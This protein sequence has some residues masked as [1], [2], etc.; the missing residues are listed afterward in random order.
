MEGVGLRESTQGSTNLEEV[1]T[2]MQ[3][4]GFSPPVNREVD[5][6]NKAGAGL[7]LLERQ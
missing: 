1:Q 5:C 3:E 2:L 6:F 7:E 4:L